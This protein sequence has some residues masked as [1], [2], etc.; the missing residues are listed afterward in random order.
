MAERDVGRLALLLFWC[1]VFASEIH[2]SLVGIRSIQQLRVLLMAVDLPLMQY[3]LYMLVQDWSYVLLACEDQVCI[4][5]RAAF[6]N[7]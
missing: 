7:R 1:L 3:G 6:K 2:L 5:W 4:A